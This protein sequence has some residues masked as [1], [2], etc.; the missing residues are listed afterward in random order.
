M[1]DSTASDAENRVA[2]IVILGAGPAGLSAAKLL[3]EMGHTDVTLI[4]AA[5]RV[6]GKCLSESIDGRVVEFGTCYAIYAHKRIL[7]WMKALDVT[8]TRVRAQDLNEATA[9][10]FMNGGAGKPLIFQLLKYFRLRD[11]IL[12]HMALHSEERNSWLAMPTGAWLDHHALHKIKR[13]LYRVMTTMGYGYLDEV[14]LVHTLRWIDRDLIF[15]GSMNYTFMPDK[16]WQYFWDRLCDPMHVITSDG[17]AHVDRHT[18]G[19]TVTL[20]S[21]RV[22]YGHHIINTLPMDTF[23]T[24]T[25][26]TPAEQTVRDAVSWGSYV[27]TLISADSWFEAPR[28]KAWTDAAIDS[29]QEGGIFSSRYEQASAEFGGHLYSL[30]QGG[31]HYE[32]TE[33]QELALHDA[34]ERGAINAKIIRQKIWQYRPTYRA[35]AIRSGLLQT[36]DE[37]QGDNRTFHSGATFSHES[38]SAVTEFNAALMP[39]IHTRALAHRENTLLAS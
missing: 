20:D 33:L 1:F 18:N 16:G 21:G 10:E 15:S 38:V 14:P 12:N 36:M 19:V 27:M 32:S 4:E 7:R 26:L 24:I 22:V 3:Q 6:G 9:I 28:V 34:T 30:G 25:E 35:K 5:D 8:T 2:K 11:D 13:L 37:M 31:G 39:L 29:K 23:G 17:A